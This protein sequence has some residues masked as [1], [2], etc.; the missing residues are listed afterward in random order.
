M[1]VEE[2]KSGRQ[3]LIADQVIDEAPSENEASYSVS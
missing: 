1:M 3:V 2:E